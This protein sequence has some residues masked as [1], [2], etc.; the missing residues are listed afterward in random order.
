MLSWIFLLLALRSY[1]LAWQ[2]KKSSILRALDVALGTLSLALF[3]LLPREFH[4]QPF[5]LIAPIIAVTLFR[6]LSKS[7]QER[8]FSLQAVI[9][10][11]C[12]YTLG[13]FAAV[14]WSFFNLTQD[15]RVGKIVMTGNVKSEWVSWKNPQSNLE[16]AWLDCYEVIVEDLKGKELSRQYLYGDLVGLRAEVLT[17]HWP[18]HLLGFSNLC[19]LE[20]LHNS[21]STSTRHNLFPHL[22]AALPFSFP[23]LQGLWSKLYHS[24]W[25][26]PGIK[27]ATLEST[28]LPLITAQLQP[29]QGSYWLIVGNSGLTSIVVED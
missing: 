20:T 9:G 19:H 23:V 14:S 6:R 11:S 10:W 8:K 7:P 26:I 21:Y 25:K 18:F 15:N 5:V 1:I 2:P 29:N 3:L 17:I 13:A 12:L 24:N 28:Y 4:W 22:A 16:G 27:S